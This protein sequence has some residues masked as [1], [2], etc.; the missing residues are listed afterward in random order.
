[1]MT[2]K[3]QT[4]F[5]VDDDPSVRKVLPRALKQHGLSVESFSSADN[6]L[7]AYSDQPGCLVL[8]V[9]MPNMSGLE[10]QTLLIRQ[11]INL[12]I[13]FITGHGGVSESVQAIKSGAID[14][15]EKPFRSQDL[16]QLISEAFSLN[17]AV[18][19]QSRKEKTVRENLARLTAREKDVLQLLLED[20]K[21]LSSKE[22]AKKL[23]ISHR[24]VE[25]HRS[26]I[27]DKTNTRSV[28]ELSALIAAVGAPTAFV[29]H[30][31]NTKQYQSIVN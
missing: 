14:F 25:H 4:V 20:E 27:L 5:L 9:R 1:M 6:F 23:G 31:A 11:G 24:T 22:I 7:A 12:P 30:T 13:I 8:D 15:L 19:A 28:A 21:I 3:S 10:L 17:R 2:D 16:I 29:E 26:R 18:T